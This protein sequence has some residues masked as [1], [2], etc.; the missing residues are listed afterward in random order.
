MSDRGAAEQRG[1][2]GEDAVPQWVLDRITDEDGFYL[3]GEDL[4][5]EIP[6]WIGKLTNLTYLDL[7]CN[8]SSLTGPIPPELG[9]LT[10]LTELWL[11]DN[12]LTGPIPPELGQLTNLTH[13]DLGRNQLT[14]TIPAELGQ[15]TNL[16]HLGLYWNQLTGA[17]PPELSQLTNL[18]DLWLY[19]NQLTGAIPPELSQLTNLTD[20]RLEGNQLTGPIPPELG[21]LT[22]L[23]ELRLE[24][25]QLTGK[26]PR[27]LEGQ[28]LKV[29]ALDPSISGLS[30]EQ[31]RLVARSAARPDGG[32]GDEIARMIAAGESKT[33]EF[34]STLRVNLETGERDKRMEHAVLKN[35]AAFLNTDGGA[36]VIGVDDDGNPLGLDNDGFLDKGK[37]LDEDKMGLHLR[38]IV[39]DQIGANVWGSVHPEFTSYRNKRVLVIRCDKSSFPVYVGKNEEFYIR[40][41][42][43]ATA[44]PTSQIPPYV[45]SHFSDSAPPAE[46]VPVDSA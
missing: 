33:V 7:S 4:G 24:G 43:G 45:S 35:I 12:Q 32:H 20:L 41:G 16:T 40:T 5:G 11:N 27:T 29:L 36:L 26:L 22:N 34:K 19:W 18:T 23:T 25:N 1:D 10:N 44:L 14:G 17:I 42:P 3:S 30:P 2:G 38:N 46:D 21:Q 37:M 31:Q 39:N 15:L 8:Y 9:Q 6:A 28:L 13:L